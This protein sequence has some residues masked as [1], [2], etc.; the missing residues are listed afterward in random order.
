MY[1]LYSYTIPTAYFHGCG[2]LY[3][4][5]FQSLFLII[6]SDFQHSIISRKKYKTNSLV[7]F[8]ID[9]RSSHSL[10]SRL[11][12]NGK[13]NAI[14]NRLNQSFSH[15]FL[16][17]ACLSWPESLLSSIFSPKNLRWL[18]T[19]VTVSRYGIKNFWVPYLIMNYAHSLRKK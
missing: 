15:F 11:A 8:N 7:I 3:N 4:S 2:V 6:S 9:L 14:N 10:Y 13:N 12:K 1:L 16:H 19:T 18:T 17:S 5:N